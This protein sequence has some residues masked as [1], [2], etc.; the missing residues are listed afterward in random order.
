MD[1]NGIG[2]EAVNY[3]LVALDRNWWR[4]FANPVMNPWFHKI[5][6]FLE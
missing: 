1:L 3:I 2:S 5:W 6:K 4:A